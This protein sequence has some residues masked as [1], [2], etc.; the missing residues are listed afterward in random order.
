MKTWDALLKECDKKINKVFNNPKKL[1]KGRQLLLVELEFDPAEGSDKTLLTGDCKRWAE[2][3]PDE[4]T[5]HGRR[6]C[7]SLRFHGHEDDRAIRGVGE[8]TYTIPYPEGLLQVEVCPILYFLFCA[9][10]EGYHGS[11][12]DAPEDFSD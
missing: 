1:L 5:P 8:L 11:G 3:F 2:E 6:I 9:E 10:R 4:G 7:K 12:L